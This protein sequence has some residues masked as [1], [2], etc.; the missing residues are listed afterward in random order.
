[1]RCTSYSVKRYLSQKA[2]KSAAFRGWGGMLIATLVV[3]AG[4]VIGGR[5]YTRAGAQT[6]ATPS[7]GISINAI[8]SQL[9]P[10]D[11]L[12]DRFANVLASPLVDGVSTALNWATV[13]QGPGATGGQYQWRTFDNGIER[14]IHAGKKVNLLVQPISYGSSNSGTPSYVLKD[15]ALVKVNCRGGP[16]GVPYPDFP[17][18]Y[19]KSFK[20]PY[21]AFIKQVVQHYAN[22]PHIGYIRFGLSIG[23]EIFPQC[24]KDE[25]AL[26]GFAVPQ[27]RD[28]V[29]LPY[30]KEMME[31]E[32]SLNPTMLIESPMTPWSG[33]TIW[34]DTEAKNAAA[35]GFGFGLQGLQA[36]DIAH[37]PNCT[38]DWCN[39]FNKYAGQVPILQLST[40]GPT[41]PSGKCD[42][43]PCPPGRRATGP[44]PPLLAFAVEHHANTFEL[45]P[46]D[47]LIA[48]DPKHPQYAAYHSSYAGAIA[49]ARGR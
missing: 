4:G 11:P 47:I 15:K 21:K 17:V 34:T 41:D 38:G 43:P 20:D 32:K 48:L 16:G 25:A 10:S 24:A 39:L 3:S 31:Y 36:S 9:N 33:E 18:V 40:L 44:L 8:F 14:F 37:Y 45:Y 19:E 28:R 2:V 49:A 29:W 13:D 1:M 23:N 5:A 12:Y 26:A 22:N 42:I 7:H 35:V 30:H 27:W 46:Q 6:P